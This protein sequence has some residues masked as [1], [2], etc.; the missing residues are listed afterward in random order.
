MGKKENR[1]STI[2]V[3][4]EKD[5]KDAMKDQYGTIVVRGE[6][7]SKVIKQIDSNP[8]LRVISGASTVAGLFF[9]PLL[10]AGLAGTILTANDFNKYKV[11]AVAND[12]LVLERK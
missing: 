8:K 12:N 7:A 9:W 3:Y 6:I 4:T 5:L 10:V 1:N 11:V 2:Q